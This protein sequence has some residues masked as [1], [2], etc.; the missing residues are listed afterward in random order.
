VIAEE[1]EKLARLHESGQLTDEEFARAKRAA[2]DRKDGQVAD[3][4]EASDASLGFAANRYVN[5]QIGMTIVSVI[6]V[7]L[8]FVVV[9]L[10]RLNA[11]PRP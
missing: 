7:L 1:L 6:V 5:F 8:V 4:A 10:P 3:G 2:L 9:F 11:F